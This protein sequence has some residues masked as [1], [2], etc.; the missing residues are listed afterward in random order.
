MRHL[1][2][3][4]VVCAT[5]VACAAPAAPRPGGTFT[6]ERGQAV[7]VAPG[8]SLH[9]E[10]VED[11]R[12]PPGV[13]CVWAGKLSYRFSIRRGGDAPEMVTLSPEQPGALPAALPGHRIV[14]DERAI[15]APPAPGT[16]ITYRA[17][18]SVAP[19]N[20]PTTP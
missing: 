9:F 8:V 11:S 3:L 2:A 5:L 6:L 10:A 20:L 17:T 13:R 12:C 15:P 14:L 1:L 16:S 18:I 4:P 19:S 7:E